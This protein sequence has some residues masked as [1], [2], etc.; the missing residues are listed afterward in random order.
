MTQVK[1]EGEFIELALVC[2]TITYD[3]LTSLKI[4]IESIRTD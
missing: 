3:R 4:L 1:G 2:L